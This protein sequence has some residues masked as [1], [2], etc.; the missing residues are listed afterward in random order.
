MSDEQKN[1]IERSA[2][3][4]FVNL[5]GFIKSVLEKVSQADNFDFLD[6]FDPEAVYM[7]LQRNLE[8]IDS[9]LQDFLSDEA[10]KNEIMKKIQE[11]GREKQSHVQETIKIAEELVE[12]EK[13]LPKIRDMAEGKV[14]KAIEQII[15]LEEKIKP[16]ADNTEEASA[17]LQ[18]VIELK[19]EL[20]KAKA[21][22]D[23][24]IEE[25]GFEKEEKTNREIIESAT[26]FDD[27]IKKIEDNNLLVKGSREKFTA[28]ALKDIVI[29]IRD[30][31]FDIKMATSK[32]GFRDKI[33][34]LLETAI[35]QIEKEENDP[36]KTI[37]KKQKEKGKSLIE[38]YDKTKKDKEE[39]KKWLGLS[40]I[41]DNSTDA[42]FLY[43]LVDGDYNKAKELMELPGFNTFAERVNFYKSSEKNLEQKTEDKISKSWDELNEIEKKEWLSLPGADNEDWLSQLYKKTNGD[44]QKAQKWLELPN[45]DGSRGAVT[46]HRLV[47]G[48]YNKAKELMELPGLKSIV[49]RITMYK[50][51]DGNLGALIKIM[52]NFDLNL[53]DA[54]TLYADNNGDIEAIE[55]KLGKKM[56]DSTIPEPKI[57]NKISKSWDELSKKEKQSWQVQLAKFFDIPDPVTGDDDRD[58]MLKEDLMKRAYETFGFYSHNLSNWSELEKNLPMAINLCNSF[59]KNALEA[60]KWLEL[61]NVDSSIEAVEV[62]AEYEG[63]IEKAKTALEKNTTSK[64]QGDEKVPSDSKKDETTEKKEYR[65]W[66]E[67]S[68]EEQGKWY[69]LSELSKEKRVL[70]SDI[71]DLYSDFEGDF[72][73]AKKWLLEFL[74]NEKIDNNVASIG[75][76]YKMF[77]GDIKEAKKSLED[78]NEG[79]NNED[80]KSSDLDVSPLETAPRPVLELSSEDFLAGSAFGDN[81]EKNIKVFNLFYNSLLSK[82]RAIQDMS[83]DLVKSYIALFSDLYRMYKK[84]NTKEVENW[85]NIDDFEK[86]VELLDSTNE[87]KETGEP[88][89][90]DVESENNQAE[91]LNPILKYL[92]SLDLENKEKQPNWIKRGV[93]KMGEINLYN[94]AKPL[95]KKY[96]NTAMMKKIAELEKHPTR[97]K[98]L[99]VKIP[100]N[101]LRV[102]GKVASLRTAAGFALFYAGGGA[103]IISLAMAGKITEWGFALTSLRTLFAGVG[104]TVG[105]MDSLDRKDLKKIKKA[106]NDIF[107]N[108]EEARQYY[109]IYY[110]IPGLEKQKSEYE[111]KSPKL[112]VKVSNRIDKIMKKVEKKV[113]KAK[114]LKD[115]KK[116]EKRLELLEQRIMSYQ[117]YANEND[118]GFDLEKDNDY[119]RLLEMRKRETEAINP[120]DVLPVMEFLQN[121]LNKKEMLGEKIDEQ[122]KKKF[123]NT[124]RSFT[125]GGLGMGVAVAV[126]MEFF[127]KNVKD[128]LQ[129]VGWMDRD[130]DWFTRAQQK[131]D[132]VRPPEP[133]S[134]STPVDQAP[135][136]PVDQAP[137]T[138]VEHAPATPVEHAP[139]TPVEHA[140]APEF[141]DVDNNDF[142][143]FAKAE[144]LTKGEFDYLKMLQDRYG[145]NPSEDNLQELLKSSEMGH[146]NATD[147]FDHLKNSNINSPIKA[148]AESRGTLL[149]MMVDDNNIDGAVKLFQEQM[150]DVSP[151]AFSVLGIDD[152]NDVEGIK[153]VLSAFSDGDN[154]GHIDA[155][156]NMYDFL[157]HGAF[158][159]MHQFMND[160]GIIQITGENGNPRFLDI[161]SGKIVGGQMKGFGTAH[162]SVD[163]PQ[164][165]KQDLGKVLEQKASIEQQP[166]QADYNTKTD[167]DHSA[168]TSKDVQSGQVETNDLGSGQQS[169]GETSGV[170]KLEHADWEQ[171]ISDN[172]VSGNELA[173]ELAKDSV[174]T[175]EPSK[176]NADDALFFADNAHGTASSGVAEA[177][178]TTAE[179]ASSGGS[180]SGASSHGSGVSEKAVSSPRETVAKTGSGQVDNNQ[181]GG[182]GGNNTADRVEGKTPKE[183]TDADKVTVKEKAM[184]ANKTLEESAQKEEVLR[185]QVKP[186][187]NV[188]STA[189][190]NTDTSNADFV[191]SAH[192]LSDTA[193]LN[194][195]ENYIENLNDWGEKALREA[196]IFARVMNMHDQLFD[197]GSV[198]MRQ[199]Y[200]SFIPDNLE[201]TSVMQNWVNEQISNMSAI[202]DQAIRIMREGLQAGKSW[203]EIS[204]S[205]S[206]HMPKFESNTVQSAVSESR[207]LDADVQDYN[208]YKNYVSQYLEQDFDE[209]QAFLR[210]QAYQELTN[211]SSSG[212]T[213]SK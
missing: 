51:V 144:H 213:A 47:D 49:E 116:P 26:S 46:I 61:P 74:K 165:D 182:G 1:T 69:S 12:F 173:N 133:A 77:K 209:K 162:D 122:K 110:D 11:I 73:E 84:G 88:I 198:A 140:P 80:N 14:N 200:E 70:K 93:R 50:I 208:K 137:A 54:S 192:H 149:K 37:D 113:V 108:E 62:Y 45:I 52:K 203:D 38:L 199:I 171:N 82:D 56:P 72:V 184:Q 42:L 98:R 204:R 169:S 65:D 191:D 126:R 86:C 33:K 148:L 158:R 24:T 188:D 83:H 60:K 152:I 159:E 67:L 176:Y 170:E 94:L 44:K 101:T 157:K 48:D 36:E 21:N 156:R 135:A 23:E 18:K 181:T 75:E 153:K 138:P 120:D 105:E 146:G 55:K 212:G 89:G 202:N 134:A 2:D 31:E 130:F 6:E 150:G 57:E 155:C 81:L 28:S 99:L 114:L 5:E 180:G 4:S 111:E 174:P 143:D 87:N 90:N 129:E 85:I 187:E 194:D 92:E 172:Q 178:R 25:V 115:V 68:E 163:L 7:V 124:L 30:G 78:N 190:Q 91:N 141:V 15:Q 96:E 63:D 175:I 40:H 8:K 166:A 136:T 193:D 103:D 177:G 211:T 53:E 196:K 128:F 9:N 205:L 206:D 79:Q 195:I 117:A 161:E 210:S 125:F 179:H 64:T 151:R 104:V 154:T 167:I 100:V 112:A 3:E 32:D 183:L 66:N 102:L 197:N 123:K 118:F 10:N 19:D 201:G 97:L 142:A 147:V 43:N 20:N 119:Q 145:F 131:V 132:Q 58:K 27:L 39:T 185:D 207:V 139:A 109:K 29:K 160:D 168:P 106:N 76:L 59:D 127:A 164:I 13:T 22:F 35:G 34:E 71:H 107:F 121:G 17:L 95:L 41:D 186:D 16:I 189:S